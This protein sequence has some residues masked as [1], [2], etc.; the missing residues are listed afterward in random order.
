M[1]NRQLFVFVVIGLALVTLLDSVFV[2]DLRE[3]ALVRQFGEI[4]GREYAP[5]LHFKLPFVQDVLKFDGRMLTLDNQTENF[6]TLEKKNVKV[7]FFVKWRIIDTGVYYEATRG[8]ESSARM[9]L[10]ASINRGLRDQ[11]ASRTIQQALSSAR[12]E[13]TKA[14]EQTVEE[15]EARLGVAIVDVR[16]KRIDFPD[17]VREKVYDRMRAERTRVASELRAKGGEQAEK[18][19]AEADR[20]ATVTVADAYGDAERLRGEGDAKASAI[21]AKAYGQDPEFYRFY[22]SLLAYRE[23][24]RGRDVLVLEPDSEFFR[25]FNSAGGGASK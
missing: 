6:L 3:R 18:I 17:E 13:A 20:Q 19:K 7:D 21:Y 23:S 12:G 22:R 9:L 2:V 14:L 8:E 4:A 25:Y 16:V 11:F 15:V 24:M 1:G 5:G 10:T